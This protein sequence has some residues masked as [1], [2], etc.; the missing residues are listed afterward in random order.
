MNNHATALDEARAALARID[1]AE[2]AALDAA[3]S[4]ASRNQV[5]FISWRTKHGAVTAER[6]RLVALIEVLEAEAAADEAKAADDTLRKR[7]ADRKVA[8]LKLAA[9]IKADLTKAN[10]ILLALVRD[11]ALAAAE[12]SEVNA[13]LPDDLEPLVPA[14]FIARSRPGLERLELGTARVWLWT[15]ARNGALIGDQGAITDLG[16]GRG[17]VGQ[18]SGHINCVAALFD[19]VEYHPAEPAQRSEPLWQIRLPRP[20]GP[21]WAFDGSRCVYPEAVFA[22]LERGARAGEPRERPV[23]IELKPV[24]SVQK[25]AAA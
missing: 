6:E 2:L 25:E 24:P 13:A 3:K 9:R 14:D 7:H 16:N 15:N 20:D 18:G 22:E 10:S 1:G 17:A 21:G 12:D 11:V 23:E 8:N 5:A 19:Q 4:E